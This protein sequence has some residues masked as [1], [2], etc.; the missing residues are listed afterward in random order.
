MSESDSPNVTQAPAA[1]IPKAKSTPVEKALSP[2]M[3][4]YRDFKSQYPGY[5]LF[6]RMGDFYEMFWE[7]AKVCN[8]VLGVALTSRN[9]GSPD[10]IPMAGVPFHAVENYLRKMITAGHKVAICEQMEDP[11]LAKGVVRREVVRLMTPGTLTDEALLDGRA[12]NYV[13]AVAFN[14]TTDNG[15]R[16]G[17]A[18]VDLST[19]ACIA[20]SGSEGQVLDEIAR[21]QPAEVLVPEHATGRPHEVS[22]QIEKLGATK[23]ITPRA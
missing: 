11:A 6:F 7:D 2:A 23:A 16:A 8:K 10:E 1:A 18:W 15:Y 4:Q 22:E 3:R 14:V 9:K 20:T 5:V 19:G 21:L 17:L 13:A 12:D